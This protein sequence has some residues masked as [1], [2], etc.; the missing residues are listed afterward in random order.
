[1]T[2]WAKLVRKHVK[3]RFSRLQ[4]RAKNAVAMPERRMPATITATMIIIVIMIMKRKVPAMI[5]EEA[6]VEDEEVIAI[7]AGIGAEVIGIVERREKMQEESEGAGGDWNTASSI[8]QH[9][10]NGQIL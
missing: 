7:G 3:L 9:S 1:M 6:D 8:Q 5:A 4:S 10:A 2:G